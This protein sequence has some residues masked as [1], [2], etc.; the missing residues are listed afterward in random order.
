[1]EKERSDE[2][3]KYKV[4]SSDIKYLND[5]AE[6]RNSQIKKIYKESLYVC[7]LQFYVKSLIGEATHDRY[8]RNY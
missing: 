8:Q 1:V 7:Y 4:K 2:E 5:V 6:I 3:L